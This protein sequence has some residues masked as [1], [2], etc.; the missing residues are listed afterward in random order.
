[1]KKPKRK[2]SIKSSKIQNGA[3]AHDCAFLAWP[4]VYLG[5]LVKCYLRIFEMI[6][7][8]WVNSPKHKI[9]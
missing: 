3:L 4:A 5:F 8:F 6:L 2:T 1:M 9:I 7:C